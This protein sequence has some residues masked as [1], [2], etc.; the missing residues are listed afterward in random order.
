MHVDILLDFDGPLPDDF[1]ERCEFIQ[2]TLELTI[3]DG[4]LI[5]SSTNG[6][7]H[8]RM[9]LREPVAEWLIVVM[10]ALLGS[11]YRRETYNVRRVLTLSDA[12]AFWHSRW[13]VL[14]ERKLGRTADMIDRDSLGKTPLKADDIPAD[15]TVLT[16][17]DAEQTQFRES[18][19][20]P[21]KNKVALTFAE[22]PDHVY[23][24]NVTGVRNLC[25]KLGNDETEWAGKRVPLVK[26]Q[27]NDPRTPGKTVTSLW[28]AGVNQW[29]S[30]ISK[31]D[32]ASKPA[33]KSAA[34]RGS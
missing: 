23:Y 31:A 29:D 34:K 21:A 28:V 25:D 18:P 32:K 11:D 30:I 4:A 8:V 15:A 10:Q 27:A 13:N 20:Q 7:V 33:A 22:F 12:P 14:Y 1:A 26:T 5:S 16:I 17:A 6:G 2:R 9:R 24:V 3:E 19:G